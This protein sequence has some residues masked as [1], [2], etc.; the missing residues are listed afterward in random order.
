MKT[1]SNPL[2]VAICRNTPFVLKNGK[3]V[4][5]QRDNLSVQIYPNENKSVKVDYLTKGEKKDTTFIYF[6]DNVDYLEKIKGEIESFFLI[7]QVKSWL[8]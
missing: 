4:C 7:G 5:P 1:S 8:T 3:I 2:I 6:K